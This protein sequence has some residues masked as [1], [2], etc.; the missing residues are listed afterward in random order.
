VPSASPRRGSGCDSGVAGDELTDIVRYVHVPESFERRYAELRSANDAIARTAS[1]TAGLLYGIGGCIVAVLW[2]ARKRLLEWRPALAAGTVVSGLMALMLLAASPAAWFGFDTAQSDTSF[3]IRQVGG[4]LGVLLGGAVGYGLV[5]MAAESLSRQAF[6]HQPQLWRV[7][8]RDAAGTVQVFGRTLGGYLF[9]PLELALVAAFYYATN[10]W[11]GWWQPSSALTDPNVLSSAV[12]ALA[13]IAISLQAGFMEECVFRAVPLALGALVGARFGHRTAGIAV[14]FVLQAL[15]FG[16]AHANYPGFPSYSRLVELAVPSMIWAAIFLRYGLV[17]TILL[18]AVFDLSLF[19]IPVFLVDAPGA[20]WQR[21]LIIGAGLVPL[22]VVLARRLNARAWTELPAAL[23]NG[24]WRAP[25]QPVEIAAAPA[26]LAPVA[27]TAARFQRALP[28]LAI[29]GLVAWVTT[30]PFRADVPG[31]SLTRAQAEAAADAALAARGVVLPSTWRRF[32]SGRLASDDSTQWTWHKFVWQEAGPAAYRALIGA[33]LAPPLWEVRYA[34]FD[35]DVADRAEEWRVTI[36]ADGRVRQVRHQLPEARAGDKPDRATALALAT[37]ELRDR[38]GLDPAALTMV[39]AEEKQRPA[40]TDWTFQFKDPAIAVGAGGEARV[41]VTTAGSEVVGS[42]R[43][44]F[45]PETWLR[46]EREQESRFLVLR[47]GGALA[48]A[49]VLLAALILGVRS[50]TRGGSDTRATIVVGS[51]AIVAGVLTLANSWPLIAMGLSTTEPVTLQVL[52]RIA[53]SLVGSVLAALLFGLAAG[54]GMHAARHAPRIA[55]AG[56]LPAWVAGVAAA[57][58]VAGL[59]AALSA[60]APRTAPIWPT[61]GAEAQALPLAAALIAGI[62]YIGITAVALLALHVLERMTG[63]WTKRQWIVVVVL[64]MLHLLPVIG[65]RDVAVAA[66]GAL[67]S[68]V[69][70]AAVVLL[71]FRYDVRTVPAY[72]AAGLILD[73]A[74]AATQKGTPAAFGYF[75][76][77][78]LTVAVLAWLAYRWITRPPTPVAYATTAAA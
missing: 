70:A 73:A 33:T 34:T 24:A 16:G 29:A 32:S 40:R 4:A 23:Y 50:W 69:T 68:G 8:S 30:T 54:V 13:P 56:R 25:A 36:D 2:L 18:H 64:V 14:A 71:L 38:F 5:F 43:F 60:L 39:A 12:P 72:L 61:F 45:V 74:V 59:S 78:A 77:Y 48:L 52:M 26:E 57:I 42:G 55:L 28:W 49:G 6:G 22:A 31:L 62:S 20:V 27:G 15:V 7:W 35:G 17:P 11:L 66:A 51:V 3:W 46:A 47:V 63:G 65:A 21:A 53:G 37:R 58:F 10:R 9:V 1:L 44:V 67:A 76:L 75:A 41:Q 19:A